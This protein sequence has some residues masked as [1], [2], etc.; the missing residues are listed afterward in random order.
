[1]CEGTG[2]SVGAGADAIDG[3]PFAIFAHTHKKFLSLLIQLGIH[4]Q[5][6]CLLVFAVAGQ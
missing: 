5:G 3:M 4:I 2:L 6:F 1:V